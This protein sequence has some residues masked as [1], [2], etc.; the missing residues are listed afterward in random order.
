MPRLSSE[1]SLSQIT[2][3]LN[4]RPFEHDKGLT[5]SCIPVWLPLLAKQLDVCIDHSFIR[6]F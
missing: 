2:Q 1:E 4:F 5:P 6:L 3:H